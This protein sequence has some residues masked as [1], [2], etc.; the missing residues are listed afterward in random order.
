M[1]IGRPNCRA[2]FAAIGA[3]GA[4]YSGNGTGTVCLQSTAH[5]SAG[6]RQGAEKPAGNMLATALCKTVLL[7]CATTW[8]G[9]VMCPGGGGILL[10]GFGNLAA[11]GGMWC[12]VSDKIDLAQL[13]VYEYN[14][15]IL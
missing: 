1:R 15:G 3:L 7:L 6:R 8:C 11:G 4:S 13:V 10:L 5:L 14:R 12:V 2:V 9:C